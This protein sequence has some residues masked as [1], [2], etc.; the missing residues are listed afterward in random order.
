MNSPFL[1]IIALA[2]KE[3]LALLRDKSSRF[4]LIGPPIAQLLVFGYAASYDLDNISV[5]IYNE[6]RGIASR[7][8]VGRIEGSPNINVLYRIQKESEIAGL[9]DNRDVLLVMHIDSE[10][11]ATIAKGESATVQLLLDGRNSNTAMIALNYLRDII[12]QLNRQWSDQKQARGPPAIIE[13]R[14]WYNENLHSQ[15]FIVT[16]IV[17][18][19]TL[20]V[21]LI[22]TALS[23]AREREQGTFDQLLVTPVHPVFILIGK[24]LP[25][26]LIG[27]IEG[28]VIITL[29]VGW[30][31]IPLRGS[32]V[33]LYLGLFLFLLSAVGIGLMI[34]AICI[35]QQQAVLGAF[36]FLVPAVILSGFATPIA[37]MPDVVQLLTWIDPLKYFLV[38][39]RSVFMEGGDLGLLW[40]QFWPMAII[41]ALSLA[42][43]GWLFKHRM[44]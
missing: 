7:E 16:G 6:D 40:P 43:A 10:F 36:L 30:F 23:V 26:L 38:I 4:V 11:S 29:A 27:L 39:I 12:L 34:S 14:A 21:T 41:A 19:L 8:L 44:Y 13:A 22:V 28:G 32:F 31:D 18:L 17:G 3:F 37:N 1:L 20:V 25:G 24:A 9:I 33:A 5:A 35:T 15:W 2:L 42:M